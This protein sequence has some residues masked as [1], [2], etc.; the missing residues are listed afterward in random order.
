MLYDH[1]E[2]FVPISWLPKF[3]ESDPTVQTFAKRAKNV[4]RHVGYQGPGRPSG[5]HGLFHPYVLRPSSE[6]RAS[7]LSSFIQLPH[8]RVHDL[9]R[10]RRRTSWIPC[11][12]KVCVISE[13]HSPPSILY[14]HRVVESTLRTMN[15][16]LERLH[17]SFFFYILTDAT[18]FNKIG[19]YLPSAILVSVG[20]MFHGLDIW[21]MSGWR[22]EEGSSSEKGQ[23]Q[24]W[25]SRQ[26]PVL[27]AL[28]IMTATHVLGTAL[29]GVLSTKY[30]L[31]NY[32]VCTACRIAAIRR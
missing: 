17:A 3:L 1:V 8:R 9:R 26:R 20:M 12:G 18:Y 25:V 16:L 32:Q 15:N 19:S 23:E 29:F 6:R 28:A 30:A 14:L 24:R 31:E 5:I 13:S 27:P 22:L 7:H 2:D 21:V 11:L 4:I 10:V